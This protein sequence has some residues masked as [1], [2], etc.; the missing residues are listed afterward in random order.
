[1]GEQQKYFFVEESVQGEEYIRSFD[2]VCILPIDGEGNVLFAIEPAPAFEGEQVL[3]LPGGTVE[4]D[5][6]PIETANR[7]LQEELGVRADELT[8]LGEVRTWPKYLQVRT[9]LF[10]GRILSSSRLPGDETH[11]IGLARVPWTGVDAFIADSR[12]MDARVLAALYLARPI[13]EARGGR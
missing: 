9:H 3:G 1:M 10:L 6:A 12:P 2:E 5:E 11:P 13:V 7:E 4:D 8:Y